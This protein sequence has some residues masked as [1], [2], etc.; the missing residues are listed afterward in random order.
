MPYTLTFQEYV[1]Q[2]LKEEEDNKN[3]TYEYDDYSF[4]NSDIEYTIQEWLYCIKNNYILTH[5]DYMLEK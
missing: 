1:I 3:S 4:G 5:I 2:E